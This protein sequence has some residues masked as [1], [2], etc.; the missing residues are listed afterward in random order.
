MRCVIG[1]LSWT[2]VDAPLPDVSLGDQ[3]GHWI[4]TLL[5]HGPGDVEGEPIDLD[6]DFLGAL[7]RAYALDP[8]TGRRLIRRYILS[9]SKG[10]AKSEFA[11]FVVIAEALGPVRF[12]HWAGRGET[13]WWGYEYTP[14]EP[15]G[16]PVKRPF[17]RCLATEEMQSGNTYDNVFYI[18]QSEKAP[19][20]SAFP[21]IDV[22][23]T[24]T[25]LPSGG[26]IRPSSASSASKDGGKETYCCLDETHLFV[27]PDLKQMARTIRRNLSKRAECWSLETTT[28]FEEGA[29][30]T[31]E[32]TFDAY[33]K[34]KLSRGD[35]VFD[36]HEGPD[37]ETFDWESDEALRQALAVAYAP[38]SWVDL[39][40]RLAEIRDP[41]TPRHESVRYFLNRRSSMESDFV[42]LGDWGRLEVDRR[43]VDGERI[44]VG[45]DGSRD[46]DSTGLVAITEDGFVDV[47]GVWEPS[48]P[49]DPVPRSQVVERVA[50]VFER[51]R[52]I[53]FLADPRYWETD[54]DEW[55][56]RFGDDPVPKVLELPQSP[57]RL[58]EAAERTVTLVR[59][60]L[61]N[62]PGLSHSGDAKLTEHIGNARRDRFGGRTVVAEGT[63][64]KLG[65]KAVTRRI[66]LAAALTFAVQ[67]RGDAI[68]A[69]EFEVIGWHVSWA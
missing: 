20:T 41:S 60:A 42:P 58:W 51:F 44:C 3:V 55:A 5:C 47:L 2:V 6:R 8:Q 29:G 26:E 40:A 36:H 27:L 34:G 16:R 33:E 23:L 9:R 65:K 12:D 14:G 28:M 45:F 46:R 25:F 57:N 10:R 11:G 68:A 4:E 56:V 50:E 64:W 21:R 30:S 32:E 1:C 63:K 7:I 69:G 62:E 52:V 22:G 67:A 54:L 13:S 59:A 31:A 49:G 53:R 66:D 19:I 37:P 18:L 38:A 15:V 43:L 39:D 17:I 48:H 24:R 61:A 35:V